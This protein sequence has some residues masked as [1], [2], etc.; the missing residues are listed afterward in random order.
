M[1]PRDGP[2]QKQKD[3]MG[4]IEETRGEE[5][6]GGPIFLFP[7][8]F[9]GRRNAARGWSLLACFFWPLFSKK[10]VAYIA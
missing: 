5:K 10:T 2:E 4:S 6:W 7:F 9:Y 1:V 3:G 8:L